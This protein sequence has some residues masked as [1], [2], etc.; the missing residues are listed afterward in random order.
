[1]QEVFTI[2]N[3]VFALG[4]LGT[5]FTVYNYFRTPQIKSEQ[6]DALMGSEITHIKESITNLKDNHIHSLEVKVDGLSSEVGSLKVTMIKLATI[7]DE[8][9][10][11]K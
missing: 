11:K 1:M 6:S 4:L 8:R 9:I 5:I 3:I 7:I 10:P 2:P